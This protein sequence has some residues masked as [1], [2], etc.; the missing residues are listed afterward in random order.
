VSLLQ[1]VPP[2]PPTPPD[3]PVDP[4]ILASQMSGKVIVTIVIAAIVAFTIVVWPIMR[5]LARRM[6]TKGEGA[7]SPALQGELDRVH[8]R[9]GELDALQARVSELEER[10]DFAE[11]VLAQPREPDRLQ[12]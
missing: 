8:Q 2:V 12:R 7:A 1:A 11:R 4:N 9:L 5:A 6:E 3:I 10:L